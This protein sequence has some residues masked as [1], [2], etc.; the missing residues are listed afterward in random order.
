MVNAVSRAR[1]KLSYSVLEVGRV[2]SRAQ[3]ELVGYGEESLKLI[4]G[5]CGKP[6]GGTSL[7][8]EKRSWPFPKKHHLKY[9]KVNY[10]EW[11]SCTKFAKII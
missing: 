2:S 5:S 6:V 10:E 4:K 9:M 7:D 1:L 3:V 8:P 11:N